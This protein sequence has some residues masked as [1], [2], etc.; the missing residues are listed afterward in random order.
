MYV[1]QPAC[2]SCYQQTYTGPPPIVARENRPAAVCVYCGEPTVDG[3]SVLIDPSSDRARH[4]T[5][6]TA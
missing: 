5:R 1:T 4:P 2:T 6:L 3:L